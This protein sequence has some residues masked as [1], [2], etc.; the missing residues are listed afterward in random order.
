[1]HGFFKNFREGYCRFDDDIMLENLE[2]VQSLTHCQET[3]RRQ[4]DCEFVLY[5]AKNQ[6]CHLKESRSRDCDVIYGPP[7]PLFGDCLIDKK[8][9]FRAFTPGT[10][11]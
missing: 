1:M 9:P 6:V 7:D 11:I 10:P 3:C 5:E 4:P 8:I 2:S